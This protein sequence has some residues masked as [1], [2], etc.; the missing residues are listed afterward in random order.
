MRA[1]YRF[2]GDEGDPW[3]IVGAGTGEDVRQNSPAKSRK[4]K[5]PKVDTETGDL[6]GKDFS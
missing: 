1:L 3:E 6:K 5:M 4:E 2:I